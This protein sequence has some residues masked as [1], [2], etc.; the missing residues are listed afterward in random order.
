MAR[1]SP[2]PCR[3]CYIGFV[4]CNNF[5][6]FR[7]KTTAPEETGT[8]LLFFS[9]QLFLGRQI[10]GPTRLY[11][12]YSRGYGL[13]VHWPGLRCRASRAGFAFGAATRRFVAVWLNC[14]RQSRTPHMDMDMRWTWTWTWTWTWVAH[15]TGSADLQRH[16]YTYVY[17]LQ[18]D[19]QRSHSSFCPHLSRVP[20]PY[21]REEGNPAD[22]SRRA[23]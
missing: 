1:P 17:A 4:S 5:S 7:P 12:D 2:T 13:R 19:L 14:V 23:L 20:S 6:H 16:M 18:S 3:V 9:F 21:L 10:G 8:H 15:A 22:A 11:G